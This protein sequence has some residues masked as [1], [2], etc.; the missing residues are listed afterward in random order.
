M[1][2]TGPFARLRIDW[3]ILMYI[4]MKQDKF[5]VSVTVQ[6]HTF[7]YIGIYSFYF[8]LNEQINSVPTEIETRIL[9]VCQCSVGKAY[10]VLTMLADFM[11]KLSTKC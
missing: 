9:N 7:S 8:Q 4:R 1:L 2:A 6:V 11:V 10:R 5:L 3:T